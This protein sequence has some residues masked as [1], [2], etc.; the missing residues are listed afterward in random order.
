[1]RL[2]SIITACDTN[3]GQNVVSTVDYGKTF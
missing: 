2:E 1:M 3:R